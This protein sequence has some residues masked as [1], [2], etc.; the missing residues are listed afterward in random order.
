MS[1]LKELEQG[2][3]N[4]IVR[5]VGSAFWD[6][7]EAI[8]I[9]VQALGG[10]T[11]VP[12]SFNTIATGAA[13][14]G[15]LIDLTVAQLATLTQGDAL[16]VESV[17][18]TFRWEPTSVLVP[19]QITIVNPTA[20]GATGRFVRQLIPAP[21]WMIQTSWFVDG[22]NMSTLANDE[23]TGLTAT[24]PLLTDLERQR[25]MG[26]VP[27]WTQL[28]Y[29]IRY[30]SDI[31]YVFI[32][33]YLKNSTVFVH[34]STVD[35]QGQTTLYTG[36]IDALTAQAPATNVPYQ[37][38]SNA[39]PVSWTASGLISSATSPNVRIR[40]TSNTVGAVA[41]AVF[42]QGTKQARW[43]DV[44]AAVAFTAPFA[45][46]NTSPVIVN[47]STF[48]VETLTQIK[49]FR[50]DLKSEGITGTGVSGT[51][52][53]DSILVGK[54]GAVLG[55][56]EFNSTVEPCILT[57][58]IVVALSNGVPS[59]SSAPTFRGCWITSITVGSTLAIKRFGNI[60]LFSGGG[61]DCILITQGGQQQALNTINF[62][63]NFFFQN[64]TLIV[65]A[66]EI[67]ILGMA[68]FD[69]PA[70]NQTGIQVNGNG[71]INFQNNAFLWGGGTVRPPNFVWLLN[72]G[73][74]CI[75]FVN[76]TNITL[77]GVIVDIQ[78]AQLGTTCPAFDQTTSVFTLPRTTSFANLVATV[79]AGGFG[80][81]ICDPRMGA[82][83]GVQ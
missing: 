17:K 41:Y 43:T 55:N 38:T 26:P 64:G 1:T 69:P 50:T 11:G 23:N 24:A 46:N 39:I 70:T 33:G 31:A 40:I 73:N 28:E 20:N 53:F 42:D 51:V 76:L 34:G 3:S 54:S 59:T 79:A 62:R 25:R 13:G 83:V 5:A 66:C 58:C 60:P 21:E 9:D 27:S 71:Q 68:V 16:W 67:G 29:H 81:Q 78:L 32:S 44:M 82:Y 77:R 19:D 8:T 75:T 12:P 45:N 56:C 72:N 30:V 57:G 37:I 10:G 36:T 49:Y 6:W 15:R 14:S 22:S 7:V 35:G 4:Q 65:S 61:S 47:G 2:L 63:N 74:S 48:V 52:V 80:S 18:D